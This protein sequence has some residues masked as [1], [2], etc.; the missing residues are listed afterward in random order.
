M[1]YQ[2]DKDHKVALVTGGNRGIGKEISRQLALQGYQVLIGCREV[3]KGVKV[4]TEMK[5]DGLMVATSS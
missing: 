4:V 1:V 2:I 3:E 5:N